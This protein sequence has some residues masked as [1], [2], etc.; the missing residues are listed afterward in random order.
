MFSLHLTVNH[1]EVQS[2]G[3]SHLIICVVTKQGVGILLFIT[4]GEGR[5]VTERSGGK[6]VSMRAGLWS[7]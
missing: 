2:M 1:E 3:H 4:Q 5:Q 6:T 7:Q